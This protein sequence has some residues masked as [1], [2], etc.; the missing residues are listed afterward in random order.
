MSPT[1]KYILFE[2]DGVLVDTEHWYHKAGNARLLRSAWFWITI[3]YLLD[4]SSG[5]GAWAQARAGD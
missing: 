2:Q 1:K 4:M 3:K 5:A